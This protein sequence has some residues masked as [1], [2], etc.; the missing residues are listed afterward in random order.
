MFSA[1]LSN[2]VGRAS[3]WPKVRARHLSTHGQCEAC[4]L[5]RGLQVHHKLP[6]HVSPHREL[7][8]DN[9]ITLCARCHLFVG[10][11]GDWDSWNPSVDED[12]LWWRAKVAGRPYLRTGVPWRPVEG[13]LRKTLRTLLTRLTS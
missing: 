1:F 8:E 12:A 11:L 4:G 13:W 2:L 10:H 3:D 5:K 7:D 9:L 6:V